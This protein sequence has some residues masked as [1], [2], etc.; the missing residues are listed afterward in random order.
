[1]LSNLYRSKFWMFISFCIISSTHFLQFVSD[2]VVE[3]LRF[4]L[5]LWQCYRRP[6]PWP[7]LWQPVCWRTALPSPSRSCFL[8]RW[9]LEIGCVRMVSSRTDID[10]KS[11]LHSTRPLSTISSA[12]SS[13]QRNTQAE[14]TWSKNRKT[15]TINPP[16]VPH[17]STSHY[18]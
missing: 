17:T 1:M 2:Q 5:T 14:D 10:K 18:Q 8:L 13:Q 15:H 9:S 12:D 6:S 16:I 11:H 3:Y 4:L 7:H